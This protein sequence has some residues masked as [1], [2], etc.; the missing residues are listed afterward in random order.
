MEPGPIPT[1]KPRLQVLNRRQALA[2][3]TAAL[4]ILEKIGIKME[5]AE[6]LDMLADAGGKVFDKD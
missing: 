5:H 2:I 1:F 3:H 4:E 6:S